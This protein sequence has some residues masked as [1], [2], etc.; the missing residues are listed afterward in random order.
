VAGTS[1][2][3][4]FPSIAMSIAPP[5][6]MGQRRI[7]MCLTLRSDFLYCQMANVSSPSSASPILRLPSPILS[8]H[9][10]PPP[11]DQ[12]IQFSL[13]NVFSHFFFFLKIG[14]CSFHYKMYFHISFTWCGENGTPPLSF[15]NKTASIGQRRPPTA[16]ATAVFPSS[17]HQ[18][19]RL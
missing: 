15:V 11:V 12:W 8:F 5:M 7:A 10:Q 18:M 2:F 16:T 19:E 4:R 14:G 6:V 17:V 1:F 9:S 13:Q 3:L